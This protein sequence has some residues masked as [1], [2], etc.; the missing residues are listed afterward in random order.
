MRPCILY[1]NVF[2][3]SYTI[4]IAMWRAVI[5]QTSHRSWQN[6][7]RW[8]VL[9]VK[10]L[11]YSCKHPLFID[12]GKSPVD[13]LS[14]TWLKVDGIILLDNTLDIKAKAFW[15]RVKVHVHK[16][17]SGVGHRMAPA[18]WNSPERALCWSNIINW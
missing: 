16:I 1:T 8:G 2:T 12:F 7:D 4:Y 18:I 3:F 9:W 5:E 15:C 13:I 14:G 17:L 6:G 11:D 10:I